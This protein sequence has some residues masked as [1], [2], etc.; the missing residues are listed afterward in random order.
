[1]GC[2]QSKSDEVVETTMTSIAKPVVF[3]KEEEFVEKVESNTVKNPVVDSNRSIPALNHLD[4]ISVK[5]TVQLS[6]IGSNSPFQKNILPSISHHKHSDH[7]ELEEIILA[8]QGEEEY[9]FD[10]D[11]DEEPSKLFTKKNS[12]ETFEN[13]ILNEVQMSQHSVNDRKQL[14][15]PWIPGMADDDQY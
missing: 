13:N 11:N 14:D 5:P 10:P 4:P 12:T 7:D 6:V 3:E 9:A 1:M 2:S 15:N 8:S